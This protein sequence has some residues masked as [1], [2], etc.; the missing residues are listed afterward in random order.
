M[1][2]KFFEINKYKEKVNFFLF[3]GENEGQRGYNKIQF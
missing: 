2:S 1:I 3:Y